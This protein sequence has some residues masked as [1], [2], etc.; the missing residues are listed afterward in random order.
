MLMFGVRVFK[1][2]ERF[3]PRERSQHLLRGSPPDRS[4]VRQMF[5]RLGPPWPW[6]GLDRFG[7]TTPEQLRSIRPK[8]AAEGGPTTGALQGTVHIPLYGE[9]AR[10]DH[11][12]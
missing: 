1:Q 6:S 5:Q 9:L 8:R 4:T 11:F 2:S 3:Q 12:D 7:P 10:G